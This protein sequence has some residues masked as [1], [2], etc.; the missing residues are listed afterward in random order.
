MVSSVVGESRNAA[1]GGASRIF[2]SY[3]ALHNNVRLS[4]VAHRIWATARFTVHVTQLQ[5]VCEAVVAII[6]DGELG[7]TLNDVA[8]PQGQEI[9]RVPVDSVSSALHSK[10]RI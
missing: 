6:A 3:K 7:I 5:S 9:S 1:A 2:H 10:I 8:R 4:D